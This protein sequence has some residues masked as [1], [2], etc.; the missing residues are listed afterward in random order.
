M[1]HGIVLSMLR[2]PL[3]LWQ[4]TSKTSVF[5]SVG[6]VGCDAEAMGYI[7]SVS[8]RPFWKTKVP[9]EESTRK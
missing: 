1:I 7:K 2:F 8:R 5:T 3:Y 4:R 6:P 9:R